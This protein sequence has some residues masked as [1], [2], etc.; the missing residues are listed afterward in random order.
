MDQVQ[1]DRLDDHHIKLDNLFLKHDSNLLLIN[2]NSDKIAV[3]LSSINTHTTRL[4][5][6]VSRITDLETLT[7]D[8]VVHFNTNDNSMNLVE[9][10]MDSAERIGTNEGDLT[11]HNTRIFTLEEEMT[12]Q[13]TTTANHGTRL[14]EAET[15]IDNHENRITFNEGIILDHSSDIIN[16][17]TAQNQIETILEGASGV[18]LDNFDNH[19]VKLDLSLNDSFTSLYQLGVDFNSNTT[20]TTLKFTNAE[21]LLDEHTINLRKLDSS[22]NLAESRLTSV[23][24]RSTDLETLTLNHTNRLDINDTTNTTQNTNISTIWET[25]YG[26]TTYQYPEWGTPGLTGLE[27]K[28]HQYLIRQNIDDIEFLKIILLKLEKEL[29]L[30]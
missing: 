19:S 6:H 5:D 12:A 20:N 8:H 16:L 22:M 27:V 4:D 11:A 1:T 26:T 30:D 23:E 29:M 28:P 13:Q 17:Q 2:N 25:L 14:D 10:R 9:A 21:T 18:R 3:N 7:D 24:D 15:A